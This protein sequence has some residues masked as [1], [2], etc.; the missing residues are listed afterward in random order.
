M[1]FIRNYENMETEKLDLSAAVYVAILI[2][3]FLLSI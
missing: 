1:F 2:I 3:V